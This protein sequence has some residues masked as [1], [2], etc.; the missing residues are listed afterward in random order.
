[1]GEHAQAVRDAGRLFLCTLIGI[2]DSAD[3]SLVLAEF[4]LKT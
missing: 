1:M 4:R 3:N 2:V